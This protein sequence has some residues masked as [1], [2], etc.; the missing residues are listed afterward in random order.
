MLP[1]LNHAPRSAA[2]STLQRAATFYSPFSPLPSIAPH[3]SRTTVAEG[4]KF[5]VIRCTSLCFRTVPSPVQRISVTCLVWMEH[6]GKRRML[7]LIGQPLT[8]RVVD[9][10]D[11]AKPVLLR[12]L[13]AGNRA[14][15]TASIRTPLYTLQGCSGIGDRNRTRAPAVRQR[16]SQLFAHRCVIQEIA[17]T[18]PYECCTRRGWVHLDRPSRSRFPR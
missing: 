3:T 4:H 18:H 16:R 2:Q 17:L 13:R 1:R 5:V 10:S 12:E 6:A 11:K 9:F 7:L 14:T 15:L 8:L